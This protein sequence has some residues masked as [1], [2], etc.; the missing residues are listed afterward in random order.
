[1]QLVFYFGTVG[2][3]NTSCIFIELAWFPIEFDRSNLNKSNKYYEVPRQGQRAQRITSHG[4]NNE[5]NAYQKNDMLRANFE[6][7]GGATKVP[8]EWQQWL[9]YTRREAPT[10]HEILMNEAIQMRT[11]MRAEKVD[12]KAAADRAEK[13]RKKQEAK[14]RAVNKANLKDEFY[15]NPE[16]EVEEWTPGK[17]RRRESFLPSLLFCFCPQ[18]IVESALSTSA[19]I[20]IYIQRERENGQA[21]IQ[22][23]S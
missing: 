5:M 1:M 22:S 19:V 7:A 11:Q 18:S 2:T 14:D 3:E 23:E 15:V 16:D 8:V 12:L 9:R 4:I 10:E 20:C 17:W 6:K 13:E 21:H